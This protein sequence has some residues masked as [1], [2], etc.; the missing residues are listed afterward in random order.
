V[1]HSAVSTGAAATSR[2]VQ[3]MR[4]ATMTGHRLPVHLA[5]QRVAALS[6]SIF[7][8]HH[9]VSEA[10]R[11]EASQPLAAYRGE[12]SNQRLTD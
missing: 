10:D 11:R 3:A 5:S 4:A 7:D 1:M 12:V 8:R 9:I 2:R 6:R